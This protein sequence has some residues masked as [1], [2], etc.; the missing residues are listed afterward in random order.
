MM[1]WSKIVAVI[2]AVAMLG[3]C[4]PEVGAPNASDNPEI[5]AGNASIRDAD[6]IEIHGR[7]IRL[8]GFDSPEKGSRCGRVNVYAAGANALQEF[9]GQKTV[10]C[11]MT[12]KMNGDREIGTC[13]VDG[14]DLGDFVVGKG[15]GRDWPKFSQC[16]YADEEAAAREALAGIWG[17][18][19]PA[20]LWG[21]RN[22]DR[23]KSCP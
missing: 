17:L 23:V 4:A 15:W 11:H 3:S 21:T 22:Y 16:A 14:V 6:T 8:S 9:L 12:G 10:T 7:A 13:E 20:D 18:D 19:C 1:E 5:L 2:S